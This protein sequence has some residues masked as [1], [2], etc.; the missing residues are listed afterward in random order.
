MGVHSHRVVGGDLSSTE[1]TVYG[2]TVTVGGTRKTVSSVQSYTHQYDTFGLKGVVPGPAQIWLI[3]DGDE[4]P[5]YQ[6]FP[7]MNNNHGDKGGN[8]VC[9]DGHV[10]W[11]PTSQYLYRYE[12]SQDEN[13][14]QHD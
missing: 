9:C 3:L 13:R 10:E 12:L 6:N 2:Q 11:V 8:V 5:L 14:T 4:P 7:D 1:I